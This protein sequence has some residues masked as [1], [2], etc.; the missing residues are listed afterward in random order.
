MGLLTPNGQPDT[1]FGANGLRTYDL[2]GSNDFFWGASVAPD[3]KSVAIVGIKSGTP[4]GDAAAPGNDDAAL[5]ILPL[6]P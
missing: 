4:V 6:A 3:K 1:T 2:G 5:L